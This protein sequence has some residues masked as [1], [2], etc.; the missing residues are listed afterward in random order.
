V[1]SLDQLIANAG[2]GPL[3]V[4]LVALL[5]GLRHA[6]DPDHLV[7]VSTLVA[8]E[9]DRP[10]QR[11]AALGAAWGCGHATT[12]FAFGAPIV[13]FGGYLPRGVEQ[14]AEALVGVVMM[15]LAVRLLVRWRAGAFH[16]HEHTHG[17]VPHRHLHRHRCPDHAHRHQVIRSPLQAVG[18]GLVHG[19]GGSAAIGVLLL[20]SID[21][22]IEALSALLVFAFG[23]ALSMAALSSG[24]GYVLGRSRVRRRLQGLAPLL[25]LSAFAFGA[26]YALGAL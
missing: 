2:S 9:P 4:L 21:A 8:T 24:F 12:L 14:A 5:L 6:S 10:A 26:W 16:V 15:A 17:G 19:V 20:A 11:A 13:L 22:R 7:A 3:L 18:V 1:A 23:T 25:G